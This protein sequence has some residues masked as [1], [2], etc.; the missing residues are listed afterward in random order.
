MEL[1]QLQTFRTVARTLS[2]TRAAEALDYAQSSVTAQVQALEDDLGVPLFERLGRRV[3]LTEAG[4]RLL[5][6]A[7]RLLGLAEEARQAVPGGVE[8]QGTVVIGAPES[9]CTYRLPP[10]L[11]QFGA[12]FPKVQLIFQPGRCADTRRALA[13]GLLDLGFLLEEPVQPPQLV[14][15]P[16]IRERLVLLAP[17]GHRLTALA[18]VGPAD[19]QGEPL[20]VTEAG[21]SYRE[22]FERALSAANAVPATTLE[23]SSVEAIKQC[24]MAGMGLT[25]LPEVAVAAEVAQGRLVIL[26]WAG[27]TY[28][29]VTQLAWHKDKW[30]SPALQ[31]FLE[32]TRAAL[33]PEPQPLAVGLAAATAVR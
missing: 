20:L 33:R 7:D 12:R 5:V 16:L 31:A 30:L 21:C 29:L 6:Y 18:Q 4:A 24:V 13:D 11:Q 10:V 28:N 23:F 27:P 15:E 19:L 14:V 3:A 26:P 25:I 22:F 1:R 9:L 17:A 2:F 32:I 8:P